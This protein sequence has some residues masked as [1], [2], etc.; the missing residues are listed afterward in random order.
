MTYDNRLLMVIKE[1]IQPLDTFQATKK[2][3]YPVDHQGVII[4]WGRA[5]KGYHGMYCKKIIT[6]LLEQ[7]VIGD[8]LPRNPYNMLGKRTTHPVAMGQAA[9]PDPYQ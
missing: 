1:F 9:V 5:L 4:R 7:A 8:P 6:L 2:T 3:P